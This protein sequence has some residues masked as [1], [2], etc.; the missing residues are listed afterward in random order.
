ERITVHHI[1][2][3]VLPFAD[4][5]A[6]LILIAPGTARH[7]LWSNREIQRV[8]HPDGLAWF[9]LPD[10][11]PF[12]PQPPATRLHTH[13]RGSPANERG[14]VPLDNDRIGSLRWLTSVDDVQWMPS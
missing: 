12:T 9:Q 14:T 13:H 10:A 8:L 3:D 6:N 11:P 5:L 1:A 7:Q 4:G 2:D